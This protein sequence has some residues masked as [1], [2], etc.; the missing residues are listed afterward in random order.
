MIREA[1]TIA[2]LLLPGAVAQV[3]QHGG[4]SA[5]VELSA[6]GETV[7]N[8]K[9]ETVEGLIAKL[10]KLE[11][12]VD[13]ALQASENSAAGPDEDSFVALQEL[14]DASLLMKKEILRLKD[15]VHHLME[16]HGPSDFILLPGEELSRGIPGGRAAGKEASTRVKTALKKA[17]SCLPKIT[18]GDHGAVRK[19]LRDSA[20]EIKQATTAIR[21]PLIARLAN[22][23]IQR[24]PVPGDDDDSSK[25]SGEK[26][27]EM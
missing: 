14:V 3:P 8:A 27:G 24:P 22:L 12:H 18:S 10:D 2:L 23:G 16:A 21:K 13:S 11:S 20:S 1:V 25:A 17:E 15:Q 19:L 6:S 9:D 5:T 4:D 26:A 7:Q